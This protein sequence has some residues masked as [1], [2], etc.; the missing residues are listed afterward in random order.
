MLFFL[1]KKSIELKNESNQADFFLELTYDSRNPPQNI[2]IKVFY[3]PY[4]QLLQR[5]SK[6][7]ENYFFSF[8]SEHKLVN[9]HFKCLVKTLDIFTHFVCV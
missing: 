3:L 6:C 5:R 8:S 4:S 9:T 7:N 1:C 2:F